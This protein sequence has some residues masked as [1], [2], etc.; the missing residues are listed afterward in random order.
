[1]IV[2]IIYEVYMS[3]SGRG[4]Q[5][6]GSG[7]PSP[8]NNKKTIAIRVPEIF[9]EELIDYA[10]RLDSGKEIVVSDNVQSQKLLEMLEKA[11]QYKANSFSQGL[12]I[13]REMKAV[14]ESVQNQ[15]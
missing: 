2:Y 13:L 4:G 5:R 9:A 15:H 7:R 3:I 8:W 10:R 14:L 6:E 12:K 11:L 1:M